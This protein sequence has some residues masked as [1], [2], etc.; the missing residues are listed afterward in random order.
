MTHW[1]LWRISSKYI[2]IYINIG[3]IN[4]IVEEYESSEATIITDFKAKPASE[5]FNDLLGA[6]EQYNLTLYD[7]N[8]LGPQSY[9]HINNV[10]LSKTWLD[11]WLFSQ[12]VHISIVNMSVDENF[13]GSDQLPLKISLRYIRLPNFVPES[14]A[15]VLKRGTS[16]IL[17]RKTNL[18]CWARY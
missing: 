11:L 9:A 6:S 3:I 12:S 1:Y 15:N 18:Y 8:L 17:E 4:S 14:D 2:Y 10:N 16:L 5:C 7:V 13:V